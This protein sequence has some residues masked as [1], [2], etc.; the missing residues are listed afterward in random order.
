MFVL[1]AML[2]VFKGRSVARIS[3]AHRA[4]VLPVVRLP[5]SLR[6]A[7]SSTALVGGLYLQ[8]VSDDVIPGSALIVFTCLLAAHGDIRPERTGGLRGP[9]RW[10]SV[11]EEEALLQPPRPT[12]SWLDWSTRGGQALFLFFLLAAGVGA[13]FAGQVAP[14]HAS[15]FALDAVVLLALFGTGMEKAMPPDLAVEPARFL[16]EVVF[17]LRKMPTVKQLRLVPRI[18]I[19]RGE[20]D[21]DE[22]RLLVVPRVPRGLNT[23]RLAHVRAWH[24]ARVAMPEVLVRVVS[25]SPS[26]EAIAW[27]LYRSTTLDARPTS[28]ALSP[29]SYGAYDG[30]NRAA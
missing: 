26:D 9:G 19:P 24:G 27:C 15:L 17:H 29:F 18:R 20:V 21:A 23:S 30:S 22:L 10:L 28:V 14:W 16:R 25:D 11:S 5:L 2:V 3:R 4:V 6:A 1:Y 12:G 7:L 13:G 8:F